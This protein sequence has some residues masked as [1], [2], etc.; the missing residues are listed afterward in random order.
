ME[1]NGVPATVDQLKVLALTNYGHF[2]SMLADDNRVRGLS[3]HLDRLAR[4]CRQ[5]F[6][7]ALDLDGVRDQVRHALARSAPVT[8]VRVTIYDPGLELGTIG[9]EAH[10]QVLV[11]TRPGSHAVAPPLRLRAV[12][13][14]REAPAVKH[15]GLFG[16][17]HHRRTAQRAGFDDV[18]FLNPDGTISELATSNI[19]FVRGG[20]VVWPRSEWLAGVTMTLLHQALDGLVLTEPL[21]PADLDAMDAAFATNAATGVRAVAAVGDRT[22]PTDHRVISELRDRYLDIPAEVV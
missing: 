17:L 22:W 7:T 16:A 2:T 21:R 15:I 14:K 1:L 5:L 20:R 19:G 6:N 3:L 12:S 13:Y 8:V 4:D 10:P 18:L 9:A 11:T